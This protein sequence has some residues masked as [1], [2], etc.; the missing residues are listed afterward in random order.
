MERTL[1][2]KNHKGEQVLTADEAK[3][4]REN[5]NS[6][7]NNNETNNFNLTINSTEPLSPESAPLLNVLVPLGTCK[8]LLPYIIR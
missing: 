7:V 8:Y 4:Y 3:D 1:I 6:I 2:Y 5:K